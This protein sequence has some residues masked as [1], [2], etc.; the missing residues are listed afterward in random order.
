MRDMLDHRSLDE[1][2]V[3]GPATLETPCSFLRSESTLPTRCSVAL[4]RRASG[5]RCVLRWSMK[6]TV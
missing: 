5:E 6:P 3:V 1:V 2:H 4:D